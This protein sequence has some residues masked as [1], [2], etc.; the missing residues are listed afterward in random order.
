M[1]L[2]ESSQARLRRMGQAYGKSR[3]EVATFA[4]LAAERLLDG[5]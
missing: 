5:D 3:Q 1:S 2:D 4:L